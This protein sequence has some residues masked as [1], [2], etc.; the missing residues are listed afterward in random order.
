MYKGKDKRRFAT[1]KAGRD[2]EFSDG[3]LIAMAFMVG[4]ATSKPVL[5]VRIRPRDDLDLA[6]S[7]RKRLGLPVARY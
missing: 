4:G 1:A 6:A 2:F 7:V 5:R 3:A